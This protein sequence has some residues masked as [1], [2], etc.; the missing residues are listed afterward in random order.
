M[1]EL[2]VIPIGH[3]NFKRI[4]DE[5]LYYVDK[6]LMIK[7]LIDSHP[8]VNLYTH[9]RRFGKTLNLSMIKYY[10]EKTEQDNSYLFSNL[11][12]SKAG[13]RYKTYMG[14]YPVISLSLKSM[15]QSTFEDSFAEYKTLIIREFTRHQNVLKSNLLSSDEE[16]QIKAICE[17]TAERINYAT[18]IRLLSDCLYKVY[19]EKVIILIDEYDVPL[20][21]AYFNG[22]FAEMTHL[23]RSS[24]ESSLKTN[25][26]LN[27][28]ILTGCLRVS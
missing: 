20:E 9:P 18:A 19:N 22:F 15:K 14:K 10:F 27:F 21:S 11:N 6:A 4:I 13:D 7:D 1:S 2:K 26:S 3:E 5:E 17:R 12:I 28:G 8:Y 16:K 23:I 24:F 25:S